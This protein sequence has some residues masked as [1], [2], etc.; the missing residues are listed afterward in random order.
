MAKHRRI[1]SKRIKGKLDPIPHN[2]RGRLAGRMARTQV[3][4]FKDKTDPTKTVKKTIFHMNLS[5]FEQRRIHMI[6][7]AIDT[8]DPE[9]LTKLNSRERKLYDNMLKQKQK[10]DGLNDNGNNG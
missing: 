7:V 3:I 10:G 1:K 9:I 4:I 8:N 2:N 6:K 5:P